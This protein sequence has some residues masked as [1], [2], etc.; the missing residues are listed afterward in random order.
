[1]VQLFEDA[2]A[3]TDHAS[4]RTTMLADLRLSIMFNGQHF[5][6]ERPWSEDNATKF[7]IFAANSYKRTMFK[8][9]GFEGIEK[10]S[11]N[12]SIMKLSMKTTFHWYLDYLILPRFGRL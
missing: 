5:Y 3:C 1:M 11:I 2:K 7:Q 9:S 12:V 6:V 10:G 4:R 8:N